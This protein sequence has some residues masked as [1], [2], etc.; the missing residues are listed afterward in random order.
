M[1]PYAADRYNTYGSTCFITGLYCS[2][3]R[4]DLFTFKTANMT[5]TKLF[6]EDLG[7]PVF[8]K[9][10]SETE[11]GHS[12]TIVDFVIALMDRHACGMWFRGIETH[13]SITCS[14]NTITFE[15]NS[16][17]STFKISYPH[18]IAR[19]AVLNFCKDLSQK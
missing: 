9:Q 3:T 5:F 12:Y 11:D 18:D 6:N 15:S 17:T 10:N 4:T 19:N 14:E 1:H 13:E 8:I 16:P 2:Y 7:K